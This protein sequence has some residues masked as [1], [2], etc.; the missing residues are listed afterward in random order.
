MRLW[1]Y[2]WRY[3]NVSKSVCK[4]FCVRLYIAMSSERTGTA[5][6]NNPFLRLTPNNDAVCFMRF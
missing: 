3:M 4:T 1:S 2:A 5:V 6:F